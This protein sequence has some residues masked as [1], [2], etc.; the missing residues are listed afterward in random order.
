MEKGDCNWRGLGGGGEEL[1][2]KGKISVSP[3]IL[4]YQTLLY[5]SIY[6]DQCLINHMHDFAT[7]FSLITI[8]IR[9]LYTVEPHLA[10][11]MYLVVR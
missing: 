3:S 2:L 8:I 4:L 7:H 11:A 5:E 6:T 9:F 1:G 10:A